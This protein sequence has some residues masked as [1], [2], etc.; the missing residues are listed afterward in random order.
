VPI[1]KT[2][3]RSLVLEAVERLRRALGTR[4][5]V[6]VDDRDHLRPGAKYFEWEQKGVPL[7]LEIGPRDV[8]KG[9]AF[10]KRRTG[11]DKFAVPFEAAEVLVGEVLEAMQAEMLAKAT[12]YRDARTTTVSSWDELVA[13]MDGDTGFVKVPWGGDGDDEERIKEAT[14]ATL[15]CH[16]MDAGSVEGMTCPLTGKPAHEWAIFDRAY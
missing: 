14:K 12:A 6:K 10:A 1:Y 9:Q 11:G 16:P 15:R 7:R 8:A 2:E 4:F 13:R 5:R 3:E